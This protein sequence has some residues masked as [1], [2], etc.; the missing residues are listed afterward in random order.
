[1]TKSVESGRTMN[2][3]ARSDEVWHSSKKKAAP[4]ANGG[5]KQKMPPFQEPQLATL[6]DAAPEGGEWLCEIKYDGYRALI[7]IAGGQ[8]TIYTRHALDWTHKFPSIAEAA[9]AL[10]TDGTLLDGEIVAYSS[11]GKTDFSSLQQ[12]LKNGEGKLS[13]FVFDMLREEG[14]DISRIPLLDRKERL[15]ALLANAG[16]PLI[17]ST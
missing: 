7:G 13:C 3:I 9:T 8:A 10:P 16:P 15:E 17:Y 11:D 2:A 6:V 4:K 14:K 12:A 5:G 1:Y